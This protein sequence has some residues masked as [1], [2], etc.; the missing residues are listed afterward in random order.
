[1]EKMEKKPLHVFIIPD[2]NRRW[3]KGKGL[4]PWEGHKKGQEVFRSI[5]KEIWL[6]GV[7]HLTVWGLSKDNLINRSK[8]EI[9]ILME[10]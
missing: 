7:T 4:A 10:I 8:L 3:A 6:L 5:V 1:M 9:S 2:G